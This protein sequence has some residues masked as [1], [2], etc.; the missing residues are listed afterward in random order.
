VKN[1][2]KVIGWRGKQLV[3]SE[4]KQ[5]F[6]PTG[7]KVKEEVELPYL[8]PE[9]VVR[10]PRR[11]GRT[12]KKQPKEAGRNQSEV[13][14][15][16]QKEVVKKSSTLL[17]VVTKGKNLPSASSSRAIGSKD[18]GGSHS[19]QYPVIIPLLKAVDVVQ[20]DQ[21]KLEKKV[22]SLANQ[23][24]EK[25]DLLNANVTDQQ[26]LLTKLTEDVEAMKKYFA[27]EQLILSQLSNESQEQLDPELF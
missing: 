18:T 5:D 23:T 11:P 10:E 12:T 7:S 4:P 20:Q 8:E 3:F 19:G 25:V 27:Q 13:F 17:S 24:R 22:S 9:I 15:S 26:A 21:V 2:K 16:P 6:T 1:E 14:P